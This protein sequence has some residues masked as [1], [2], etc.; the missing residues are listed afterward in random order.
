LSQLPVEQVEI[1]IEQVE[2]EQER[3][4]EESSLDAPVELRGQEDKSEMAVAC[5]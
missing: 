4:V 1:V 3:V 5:N 2:V